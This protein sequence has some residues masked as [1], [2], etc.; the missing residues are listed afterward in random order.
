MFI[1]ARI[2]DKDPVEDK[3]AGQIADC[4][5]RFGP[6][7][8]TTQITVFSDDGISA[9]SGATRP[10][11]LAMLEA[12]ERGE[13]D[14]VVA[15]EEERFSRGSRTDKADLFT[16]C[17]EGGVFWHTV[18][19]GLVNPAKDDDAEFM[20][21][22][23]DS[24]GRREVRRKTA[25]QRDRY[26]KETAA[27]KPLWGARPFGFE[28][29]RITH[30]DDEV[31]E[32]RWAYGI[33]TTGGT[34]YEIIQ[35]WNRLGVL[36]STGKS[37]SYAT[38]QQ[39]LKRPR[40]A[41][42]VMR[43][44]VEQVGVEA[45]WKP[46]VSREEWQA[47]VDIL[48]DP[49]RRTKPGRKPKHLSSSIL[50]CGV[51]GAVMRSGGSGKKGEPV[52]I[53]KC[54]SKMIGNNLG[55]RHPTIQ[56]Q[57]VDPLIRDAVVAAFTFGPNEL[58]PTQKNPASGPL[59]AD[60][61]KIRGA[62]AR[63]IKLVSDDLIEEGDAAAQLGQLK[64]REAAKT[65]ELAE[66]SRSSARSALAVDLRDDLFTGRIEVGDIVK[67]KAALGER[68]DALTL[69]EQRQLVKD[70]LDIEVGRGRGIGR[71]SITHK[72]V[73]SLN[74]DAELQLAESRDPQLVD[75]F[76]RTD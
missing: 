12:I 59:E 75:A 32:L 44:D 29:D 60:L 72:K 39:L 13:C 20:S 64:V 30:R 28:V 67:A 27:G 15:T 48:T 56:V 70:L 31:T 61:S 33:I 45:Q 50:R 10:G 17:V 18:R 36:T 22:L 19:D 6:E 42:I 68:F 43:R 21:D 40:N 65:A 9:T 51:C 5:K 38:V 76:P 74:E 23:R 47:A 7:Y 35:T 58:M 4:R 24:L 11:W 55:T 54:T 49:M 63:L 34:L 62:R 26:E 14:V 16:A 71:V 52:A 8:G 69:N 3:V 37:W 41:G 57:L 2:S 1:Y 73:L 46:I 66:L 53:Y 25:R